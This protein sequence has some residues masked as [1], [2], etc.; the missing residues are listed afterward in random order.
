MG[1]L[2]KMDYVYS[3]DWMEVAKGRITFYIARE[4]HGGA[5]MC[6]GCSFLILAQMS[7]AACV[8]GGKA[9]SHLT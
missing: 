9:S 3:M 7:I 1:K 4:G 6:W 8:E 5:V 2:V